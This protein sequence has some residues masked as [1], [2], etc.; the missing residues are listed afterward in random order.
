MRVETFEAIQRGII[1]SLNADRS[2]CDA[3]H[4]LRPPGTINYPDMKKRKIG[5]TES[6]VEIDLIND[7]RYNPS[8]FE[9][10]HA[11]EY[12][13][14][15]NEKIDA[16]QFEAIEEKFESDKNADPKLKATWDGQRSDL[17]D[18][19][20]SGYDMSLARQLCRKGYSKEEVKAVLRHNPKGRGKN[21]KEVYLNRTVNK[22][23]QSQE[24]HHSKKKTSARDVTLLLINLVS[25]RVLLCQ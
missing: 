7:R 18:K 9:E 6:K 20:R 19:S 14:V 1:R 23:F 8:D 21:G 2:C 17:S 22:V 25:P 11:E 12:K 3:S 4:V 16:A 13:P 15:K 24:S 5:R 10:F